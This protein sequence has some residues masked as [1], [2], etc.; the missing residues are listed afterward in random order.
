[1]TATK[2][3][4]FDTDKPIHDCPRILNPTVAARELYGSDVRA[5]R[6]AEGQPIAYMRTNGGDLIPVVRM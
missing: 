4:D 1:M 5:S 2:S 3:H 6:R